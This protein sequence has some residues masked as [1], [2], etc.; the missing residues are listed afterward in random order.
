MPKTR[1]GAV[2]FA[3]ARLSSF[4]VLVALLGAAMEALA[5]QD[6]RTTQWQPARQERCLRLQLFIRGDSAICQAAA[7]SAEAFVKQRRGICLEVL[8][9]GED[10]KALAE[11]RQLLQHFRVTKPAVP[12]FYACNQ[13]KIGFDAKSQEPAEFEEL[14]TIH[15]YVRLTCQHCRDA[16]RF[17]TGL[18]QRWSGIRLVYHDVEREAGAIEVLSQKVRR[19]GVTA[20]SF[21]SIFVCGRLVSGYRSDATTGREIEELL[22]KAS[23]VAKSQAPATSTRQPKNSRAAIRFGRVPKDLVVASVITQVSASSRAKQSEALEL[24]TNRQTTDEL[25]ASPGVIPEWLPDSGDEETGEETYIPPTEAPEGVE[26]P[27]VGYIRVRDWGLPAFTLLIGLVDGF[28]PCAM[29]VL[30]FLLSILV[31]VKSRKRIA[32]IAGSFVLV[33]GL[34]YFAFMA[35]W[36]N[37]F[38]IIGFA[39][40]LQ[41]ALGLLAVFVGTVNVKDF[42]VFKKGVS[43]SIPETAKPG[44]YA[45]VRRIVTA[46]YLAVAIGLSIVL[47]VVVNVVELLCTAGL[48]AVYTQILTLQELPAWKNY[49]YLGLY[50]VGYMFDDTLLVIAFVITLS[51]RRLQEGEGR[52]LKLVS[53]LVVLAL[54]L[55]MIF[56][57]DWLQW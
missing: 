30:V 17:L 36:L 27:W 51:H 50:I 24:D 9:V 10:E 45:R 55:S 53:G 32:A 14:F 15:A 40:P 1:C 8:D 33:S 23:T 18:A 43:L 2:M 38:L 5:V 39:R 20:P 11:Y 56:R 28:N 49:L 16:R 34:A 21:P 42:F 6:A 35:A 31:N 44:I 57:P 12:G 52:W 4:A 46:D 26:L 19:Y 7:R 54:G 25:D 3:V 47:A 22:W 29:W 48:P 13:L 37:L 41:I